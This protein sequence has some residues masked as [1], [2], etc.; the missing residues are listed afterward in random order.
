MVGPLP[1][2][3]NRNK[4][5]LSFIDLFTKFPETIPVPDQRDE[6]IARCFVHQIISRYGTPRFLLTDNG[7]NF[8]SDLFSAVSQI[9]GI[10][11]VLTTAYHP[12][13]N[14]V[15]ER[16]HRFLKD[17]ISHFVNK[18]ASDWEDYL[19]LAML[20]YRSA[21]NK[22]TN[23]TPFYLQFGRDPVLPFDVIVAPRR[24]CYNVE[25]NYKE[26]MV[27]RMQEAFAVVRSKLR[28][29]AVKSAAYYDKDSTPVRIRV[30]DKCYLKQEV[31][32]RGLGK[33]FRIRFT[34]PYR[35][36][37]QL[38]PVTFRLTSIYGRAKCIAHCNRMKPTSGLED[39]LRPLGEILD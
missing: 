29:A 25:D 14:G 34:G 21:P 12:Q 26:E 20:A 24:V 9:L 16:H 31:F 8:V 15:V 17:V 35:L 23:E 22:A 37:E 7:A 19:Q 28:E 4:W 6:P 30:G 27:L 3:A 32:P 38:T 13:S 5:I 36:T 1:M 2:T 33:K 18:S 11:R 39:I 10:K